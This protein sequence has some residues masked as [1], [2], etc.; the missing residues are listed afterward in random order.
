MAQIFTPVADAWLRGALLA[1]VVLVPGGLVFAGA[2]A[3]SDYVTR[4]GVSPPQPVP[5]SHE[6]H[7]GQLGIDCRYCHAGVEVSAQAGL[8][9]TRTCMTCH[10]QIWTEAP[11]LAPVR[12]SLASGTAITWHRVARVPDYVYFRHDIHVHKGVGCVTCH[13]RVDR[14]PLMVRGVAFEMHFCLAC[15]RD[16]APNLRP[17][18]HVTEMDWRPPGNARALGARLVKDYGVDVGQMTHCNVC[19]R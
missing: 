15:H 17:R 3:R 4:R 10:S 16:P 6:H 9:P 13:G 2:L 12:D 18:E 1:I 11:M 19:H 5:F 14:M 7:V 8:P